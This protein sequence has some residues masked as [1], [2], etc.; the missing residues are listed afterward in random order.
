VSNAKVETLLKAN[1]GLAE[2]V[3]FLEKELSKKGV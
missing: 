3:R 2:R 1:I